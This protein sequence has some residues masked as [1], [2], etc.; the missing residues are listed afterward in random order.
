MAS[1][2]TTLWSF[3]L[4]RL[5]PAIISNSPLSLWGRNGSQKR[6][7]FNQSSRFTGMVRFVFTRFPFASAARRSVAQH[8]HLSGAIMI[9]VLRALSCSRTFGEAVMP[10]APLG[11]Y[12]AVATSVEGA[13]LITTFRSAS[14]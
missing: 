8:V 11:Q 3:S 12:P 10:S 5:L 4:G 7:L 2:W 14:I 9:G 1:E 6:K 13:A